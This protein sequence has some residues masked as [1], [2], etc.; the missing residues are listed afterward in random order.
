MGLT[1]GPVLIGRSEAVCDYA[2]ARRVFEFAEQETNTTLP[3]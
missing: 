1:G 2:A 3:V